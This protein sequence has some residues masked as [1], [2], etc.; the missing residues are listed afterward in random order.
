[1]TLADRIADHITKWHLDEED[2]GLTP[3][4]PLLELNIIDSAAIFDLVQFLSDEARVDVPIDAIVP[5]NFQ[6]I[7]TI[8][9]L[10]E[11]LKS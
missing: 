1:M 8:V 3:D 5:D 10:V 7:G 11:K 2:I 9:A 4:T 6:T